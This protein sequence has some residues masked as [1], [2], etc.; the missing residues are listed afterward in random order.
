MPTQSKAAETRYYSI[1][2]GL[3]LMVRDGDTGFRLLNAR[4]EWL[5]GLRLAAGYFYNGEPGAD[6]ITFRD[7]ELI[8]SRLGSTLDAR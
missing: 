1:D 2:N 3:C 6:Q 8:A 5:D 4:G 7:A